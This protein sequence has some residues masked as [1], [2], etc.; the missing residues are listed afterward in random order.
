MWGL[1]LFGSE[2]TFD[3]TCSEPFTATLCDVKNLQR[4]PSAYTIL[5]QS[6]LEKML[7]G[8]KRGLSPRKE[9]PLSLSLVEEVSF[10]DFQKEV[11]SR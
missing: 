1:A 11:E 3:A 8:P 10:E 9:R 7:A 2:G 5:S 4:A 6:V